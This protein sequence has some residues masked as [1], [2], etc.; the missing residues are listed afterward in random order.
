MVKISKISN[1]LKKYFV[2]DKILYLIFLTF[3]I[4][5]NKTILLSCI[6]ILVHNKNYKNLITL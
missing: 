4:N 2:P 6:N 1:E 5:L 3:S